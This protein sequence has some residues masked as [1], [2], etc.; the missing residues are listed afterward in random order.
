MKESAEE[1]ARQEKLTRYLLGETE[2]DERLEIE[3]LCNQKQ[4]WRQDKQRISRTLSL[5]EDACSEPLK[6][7]DGTPLNGTLLNSNRKNPTILIEGAAW[8]GS[9]CLVCWT[10][11]LGTGRTSS[12]SGSTSCSRRMRASR[13]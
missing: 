8:S 11:Q 13:S 4:E 7:L 9:R 5:M 1:K 6:E 12:R 10:A 2:D 3:K